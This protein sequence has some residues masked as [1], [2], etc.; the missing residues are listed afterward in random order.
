MEGLR[1][2]GIESYCKIEKPIEQ[3]A[4]VL[5]EDLIFQLHELETL[6]GDFGSNKFEE[7]LVCLELHMKGKKYGLY[8]E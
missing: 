2:N 5:L 8:C 6:P 3:Q 1:P 7:Y 4:C